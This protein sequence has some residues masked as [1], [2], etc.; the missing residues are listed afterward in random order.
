MKIE[1]SG[2]EIEVIQGD[3]AS[4]PDITAIVNAAN[5]ELRPGGGVAGAI[6]YNGNTR[7]SLA[8]N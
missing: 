2:I 5:A 1:V 6:H 7:N 8:R 3:I 4:Q